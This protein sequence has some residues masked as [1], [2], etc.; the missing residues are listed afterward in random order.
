MTPSKFSTALTTRNAPKKT[1]DY[2][3]EI[4]IDGKLACALDGTHADAEQRLDIQVDEAF[5]FPAGRHA[6]EL[7]LNL[8]GEPWTPE[9]LSLLPAGKRARVQAGA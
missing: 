9:H 5:T 3:V 4:L 8:N 7:R 2:R 6:L 1:G